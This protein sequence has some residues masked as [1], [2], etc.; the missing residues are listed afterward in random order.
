MV[1]DTLRTE[2]SHIHIVPVGDGRDETI[3]PITKEYVPA[4]E[5]RLLKVADSDEADEALSEF[6]YA[7]SDLL[8]LDVDQQAAIDSFEDRY[9]AAY[10]VLTDRAADGEHVWVNVTDAGPAAYDVTLAANTVQAE[11]PEYRDQI[12]IYR[13]ESGVVRELPTVP[14]PEFPEFAKE[15]LEYLYENGEADSTSELAKEMNGTGEVDGSY[16]S[17]VQYNVQLLAEKGYIDREAEGNRKV[18][19]LSP[20]GEL[21]V[22]TH[23]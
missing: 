3:Y 5:I 11:T 12:H 22:R 15:V 16:Q 10:D 2:M 1:S 17:K 4:D 23:G 18:S 8:G 6:T 21:W 14:D 13:A 9:L 19:R 20:M 7:L